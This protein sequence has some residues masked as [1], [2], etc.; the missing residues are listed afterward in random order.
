[1]TRR[2]R[3]VLVALALVA[4]AIFPGVR[5]L[6][7]AQASYLREPSAEAPRMLACIAAADGACLTD[8]PR[9][10][11]GTA[12]PCPGQCEV[13]SSR[14]AY[15]RVTLGDESGYLARGEQ[16]P[17]YGDLVVRLGDEQLVCYSVFAEHRHIKKVPTIFTGATTQADDPRCVDALLLASGLGP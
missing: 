17:V 1:M 6:R 4:L 10:G 16:E 14:Y 9:G 7:F 8:T 12:G 13:D 2:R 3:A 15:R 11:D 5:V